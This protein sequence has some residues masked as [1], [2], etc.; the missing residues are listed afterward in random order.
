MLEYVVWKVNVVINPFRAAGFFFERK[1][2]F[3]C[4]LKKIA[5]IS[6][7]GEI[8]RVKGS[9]MVIAMHLSILELSRASNAIV[10]CM[11]WI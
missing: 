8:R 9:C 11:E 6:L 5:Y 10:L 4:K 1:E 2:R 7:S 3:A